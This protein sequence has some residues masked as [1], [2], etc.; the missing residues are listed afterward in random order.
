MLKSTI[1]LSFAALS[2][3]GC[4]TVPGVKDYSHRFATVSGERTKVRESWRL[5][6]NCSPD[7]PPNVRV[8]TPPQ[9]GKIEIVPG[10]IYTHIKGEGAKCNGTT[11]RGL[12]SYYTSAPGYVGEDK[13]IIRESYGDGHIENLTLEFN[14]IR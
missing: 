12:V 8:M 11:V 5:K 1:V 6:L 3:A 4:T 14:I 10:D 9:H 2:L 13:A 7:V